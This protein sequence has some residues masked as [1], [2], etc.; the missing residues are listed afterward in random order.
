MHSLFTATPHADLPTLISALQQIE[1]LLD[2][3]PDVVFFIKDMQTRYALVNQTLAQRLGYKSKG[4]L[5]GMIA[6]QVFPA[7]FGPSYTAQDRRVLKDGNAL[8]EQLEL[9]LYYGNQP[10]WCLTSKLALRNP[11]GEI[12]GLAG[13]SRDVQLPQSS[14][15]A[16]P[17]LAA[18]DAH[19]REHFARPISL[20][21]LTELAGLSVAQ[22]ERHCKRIFQLTPR[23][24]IHKA[25]LGEASRLL[26]QDLPITEI[27]LRCGYTDHSAFSR[28]FRALTGL[29]PS[30]FRDSHNG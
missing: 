8:A 30:Q 13:I 5:L 10:V 18:V 3:M 26:Q 20:A 11:A 15:P 6:E 23:Q 22:L 28:Q 24:M 25:R 21:E 12:I 4:Q 7:R 1:P 29:T 19:I 2:A 17:K 9:H 16:Y 27:A 14:H